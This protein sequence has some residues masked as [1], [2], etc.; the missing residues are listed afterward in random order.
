MLYFDCFQGWLQLLSP[1]VFQWL[2]VVT[3]TP[4][5]HCSSCFSMTPFFHYP[6]A[7]QDA[8]FPS[9]F[10]DRANIVSAL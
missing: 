9:E 4:V 7:P 5:F 10:T 1:P 2:F 8:A 3:D 6:L